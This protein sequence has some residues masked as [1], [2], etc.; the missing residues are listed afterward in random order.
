MEDL[1]RSEVSVS[2]STLYHAFFVKD[3]ISS[4]Y[5]ML[6]TA[7]KPDISSISLYA[8]NHSAI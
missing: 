8:V 2:S 6:G 4:K 3:I 1:N 7:T 5:F